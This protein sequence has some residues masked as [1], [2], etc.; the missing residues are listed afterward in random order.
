MTKMPWRLQK[1]ES[2]WHLLALCRTPKPLSGWYGS[3]VESAQAC[4]EECCGAAEPLP[5]FA[6]SFESLQLRSEDFET[7]PPTEFFSE[8]IP[9][10]LGVPP[11]GVEIVQF[12]GE[13]S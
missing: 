3:P 10:E 4:S 12:A 8:G 9:K 6:V 11:A 1:Y 2:N 7:W 5:L 13:H